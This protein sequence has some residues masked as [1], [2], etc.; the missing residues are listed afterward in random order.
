LDGLGC[1]RSRYQSAPAK[2]Y[3]RISNIDSLFHAVAFSLNDNGFSVMQQPIDDRRFERA[4]VIE[5]FEP[6]LEGLI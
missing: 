2:G 6:V 3:R 1:C 4:V 5:D